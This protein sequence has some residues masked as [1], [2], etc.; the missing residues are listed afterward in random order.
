MTSPEP[1]ARLAT[2]YVLRHVQGDRNGCA[3]V[4]EDVLDD[5]ALLIAFIASMAE[6]TVHYGR[7]S[8]PE[9]LERHLQFTH[10]QTEG[11]EAPSPGPEPQE[12]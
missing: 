3:A 1:A 10:L 12:N 2:T 8:H 7:I 4:L 11:I 5:P 6:L 9:D